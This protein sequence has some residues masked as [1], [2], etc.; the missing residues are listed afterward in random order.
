MICRVWR[1]WTSPDD[2][3]SRLAL[4]WHGSTSAWRTTWSSIGDGSRLDDPRSR[5]C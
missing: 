1:G 3:D 5:A 4:C 2:A